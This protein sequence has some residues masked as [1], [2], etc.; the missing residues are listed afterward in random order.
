MSDTYGPVRRLVERALEHGRR[1]GAE[2]ATYHVMQDYLLDR[3]YLSMAAAA[4]ALDA[5]RWP[6]PTDKAARELAR[7]WRE[8]WKVDG[9]DTV[10]AHAAAVLRALQAGAQGQEE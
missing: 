9:L 3:S 4:D 2:Y 8:M 5:R 1:Q 6:Q 7:V 10:E